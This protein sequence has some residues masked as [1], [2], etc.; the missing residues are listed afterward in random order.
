MLKTSDRDQ[1]PMNDHWPKEPISI[2]RAIVRVI[3]TSPIQPR[4]KGISEVA[5][6]GDWT[7]AN[8]RYA[9]VP[10]GIPLQETM[11]MQRRTL[12]RFRDSVFDSDAENIAPICLQK[13]PREGPIHEQTTFVEA[14][15][16]YGAS[17]NGETVVS[18]HVCNRDI[19][20]VRVGARGGKVLSGSVEAERSPIG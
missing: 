14:V 11:P 16:S 15:R 18:Y 20:F 3:P 19:V 5:S 7:L 8:G 2:L 10:R 9:I 12:R 1:L 17:S 6:W 4:P 13:R